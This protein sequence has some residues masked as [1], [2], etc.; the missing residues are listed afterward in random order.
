M[1]IVLLNVLFR[2]LFVRV[3]DMQLGFS[4]IGLKDFN[5]FTFFRYSYEELMLPVFQ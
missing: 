4:S 2:S 5:T 3:F 1:Y